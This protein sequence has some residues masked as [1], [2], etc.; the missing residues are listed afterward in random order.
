MSSVSLSKSV[1]SRVS[2]GE[3][4]RVS[5]TA[6]RMYICTIPVSIFEISILVYV[7]SDTG[8]RTIRFIPSKDS[9]CIDKSIK[10]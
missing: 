8:R 9:L 6:A 7:G 2:G 4:Q 10:G 3:T 1:R 5:Y